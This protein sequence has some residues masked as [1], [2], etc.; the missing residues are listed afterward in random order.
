MVG[1]LFFNQ[2]DFI[3]FPDVSKPQ[4]PKNVVM[5]DVKTKDGLAI[6]GWFIPPADT[7]KAVLVFFHGNAGNISHRNY[8][9][10][11]FLQNG[12]GVLLAEYRGYAGNEG[13]PEEQ[14]L[15]KDARAYIEWMRESGYEDSDIVLYGESLGTGV[16]VQMAKEH[17]DVKALILETPY[18]RLTDPARNA[19]PFIPFIEHLMHDTYDSIDKIKGLTMPKMFMVAEN[20]EVL[21]AQ[22][23]LDLYE[24]A[25][26][27]KQ[28]R[29]YPHGYH[30]TLYAMGAGSDVI[31]FLSALD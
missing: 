18:A 10:Q 16:A 25:E 6:S 28:L 4:V 5:A 17:Q 26:E 12:Y 29:L 14:G 31:E 3:Y 7:G 9:I 11:P 2:R 22:T 24:K 21:G 20:D 1:F 19:Y 30:N 8:K 15:Y 23:G 27:P 13:K